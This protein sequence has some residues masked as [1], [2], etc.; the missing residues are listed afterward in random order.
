MAEKVLIVTCQNDLTA[1]YIIGK[2]GGQIS[3][4]R[5]N[6]DHL[7]EYQINVRS[8]GCFWQISNEY[9]HIEND[10]TIAIYYRKPLLPKLEEYRVDYRNFMLREIVAF[11]D[12]IVESFPGR[13]LTRP[14]ILKRADNKVFQLA[15]AK[16]IGFEVPLSLL[17]NSEQIVKDFCKDKNTVVKPISIGKIFADNQTMIIQTNSIENKIAINNL[18]FCPS[19][20]QAYSDKDYEVRV[21]IVSNKLF[22][23]KLETQTQEETKIDW[24]IN[25]NAFNYSHIELPQEIKTMCL[26]FM[27]QANIDFGAF[28]FIVKNE[29]YIFLEVNANGQ[30]GWL[31]DKLGLKISASIIDYLLGEQK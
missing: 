27:K 19:Y 8:E 20:F 15:L 12:G 25:P 26:R 2:Y 30:W 29:K 7:N 21:T 10:E 4:F 5:L 3:F 17:S 13:C 16:K 31:E 23:A 6:T 9:H 1:D 18:E 11:V 24:R 28:D 22:P 14:S